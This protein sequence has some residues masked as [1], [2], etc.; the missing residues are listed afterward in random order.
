MNFV[1]YGIDRIGKNTF[2]RNNLKDH[3]LIELTKPPK[4]VDPLEYSKAEYLD[5][6]MRLKYEDNLV[7]SRGH[8]DEY[9]YAPKYRSYSTNYLTE[10]EN[11]FINDVSKNLINIMLYTTNFD[12]LQDDGLSLDY[13]RRQEEQ[14]DFFNLI[15]KQYKTIY[16][17]V[18]D[19][20][21]YKPKELITSD[22]ISQLTKLI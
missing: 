4:G 3:T 11:K 15:P 7:F 20:D 19:F 16:I 14:E 5:Y 1:V 22:F 21:S 10:M 9:V 13:T 8:V 2:I 12:F 17:K 6:F 18:N